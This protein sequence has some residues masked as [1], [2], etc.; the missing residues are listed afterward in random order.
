M[1][2]PT[3]FNFYLPDYQPQGVI[4]T[5]G[6]VGPE[7][8]IQNAVFAISVPNIMLALSNGTVGNFTLDLSPQATLASTP[9]SLVDNVDLLLTHGTMSTATRNSILTA[10]NG[11]TSA[12]VP[13]GSTLALTRARLAVYLTTISPDYSILK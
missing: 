2:S 3:V 11:V 6:L 1:A 4:E 12:M 7:F 8:E 10:V 13:S 9:A 5:A